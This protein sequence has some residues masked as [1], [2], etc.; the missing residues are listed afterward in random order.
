MSPEFTLLN[1]LSFLIE[2][3]IYIYMY[4][5]FLSCI[6]AKMKQ[7]DINVVWNENPS[8][9]KQ[10]FTFLKIRFILNIVNLV[11][12]LLKIWKMCKSRKRMCL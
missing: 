5:F 10:V 6:F 11:C 7:N 2:I 3:Y 4:I 9:C 1:K 12:A 8:L